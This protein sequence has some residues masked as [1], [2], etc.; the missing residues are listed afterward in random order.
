MWKYLLLLLLLLSSCAFLPRPATVPVRTEVAGN[1]AG[2][3][4]VIL[5]PGRHSS[6]SELRRKGI[7]QLAADTWPAA[8]IVSP[9]LHLAYYMNRS[10]ALRL[11]EDVIVPARK[12]GVTE[13]HLAG[14]SMGGMGAL[15]YD[16][17]H[18]GEADSI[19]LLS[20]Y[21]GEDAVVREIEAAGGLKKWRPGAVAEDDY[22]RR[23][24]LGLR[25]KWLEKGDR[26]RVLLGCGRQD[27]LAPAS[28]LFAKEFLKPDEV[29]WI[30]GAH[31]WPTWRALFRGL[32]ARA[33][34]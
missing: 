8:R 16:I 32:S 23:L 5:L 12:S 28:R 11:H 26:P 17:E 20:P 30:D 34:R 21:L 4:M 19:L 10:A 18:P 3:E 7:F 25:R 1:P 33:G 22:S 2:S 14:I 6:P 24:W 13:L 9:D 27:S 31:D 29:M 15:I